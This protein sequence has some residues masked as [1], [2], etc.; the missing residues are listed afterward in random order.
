[1]WWNKLRRFFSPARRS[2]AAWQRLLSACL[3]RED[4]ARRL[5]EAELEDNPDLSPDEAARRA[6]LRYRRD[7]G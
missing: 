7:N 4:L 1:M 5:M 6:L 3:G 2:D